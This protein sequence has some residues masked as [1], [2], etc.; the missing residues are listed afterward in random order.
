MIVSYRYLTYTPLPSCTLFQMLAAVAYSRK[1]PNVWFVDPQAWVS[2][3]LFKAASIWEIPLVKTHF[4]CSLELDVAH[5]V[6]DVASVLRHNL[7][8]FTQVV[9][10]RIG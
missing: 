5:S 3:H 4:S 9:R 10:A 8:F 2:E 7:D 1:T 6:D